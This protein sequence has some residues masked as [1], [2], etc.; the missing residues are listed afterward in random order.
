M[1]DNHHNSTIIFARLR[2]W[3]YQ[4]DNNR[5]LTEGK[6]SRT[7]GGYFFEEIG[8]FRNFK[9]VARILKAVKIQDFNFCRRFTICTRS[10]FYSVKVVG[11]YIAATGLHDESR[12]CAGN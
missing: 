2:Q 11:F 1:I 12:L 9:S 8:Q 5:N 6:D 4:Y 3:A 7:F 10:F